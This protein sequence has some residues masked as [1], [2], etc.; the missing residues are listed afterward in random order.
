M[1]GVQ[2]TVYN[3]RCTMYGVQCTVYNV[4]CTMY[5]VQCTV[6]NAINRTR[7]NK[8]I[9]YTVKLMRPVDLIFITD[10]SGEFAKMVN[11]S[12]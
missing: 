4:R 6:Y 2:C 11:Y 12:L 9:L 7:D 1:Y 5:G 8:L 10:V 3:V